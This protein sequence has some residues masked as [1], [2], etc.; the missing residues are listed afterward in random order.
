M[1]FGELRIL[2]LNE[3]GI[4]AISDDAFEFLEDSLVELSLRENRLRQIPIAIG[5]L[6]HLEIL[7]LNDNEIEYVPDDISR[8]LE[9]SLKVVLLFVFET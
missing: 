6:M 8:N 4:A 2:E 7:D 3:V 9:S 1:N 5:P